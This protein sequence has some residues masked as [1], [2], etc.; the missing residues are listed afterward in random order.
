MLTTLVRALGVAAGHARRRPGLTV[1]AVIA[2][3]VASGALTYLVGSATESSNVLL[4]DFNQPSSR[5]MLIRA[6][7]TDQAGLLDSTS[8]KALVSLPGIQTAV[9]LTPVASA[10]NEAIVGADSNIGFFTLTT[11]SGADPYRLVS[12][13][14][15]GPGEAVISLAGASRINASIP[16]ASGIDVEGAR[17]GVVGTYT[18]DD[19][20]RISTLISASALTTTDTAP[21]GFALIALTVKAPADLATVIHALPVVFSTRAPTDYSTEYDPRLADVQKSISSASRRGVRT[22]AL[23]LTGAG[24]AITALVTAINALTQ[25]REIARRRALGATRVL[26]LAILTAET[27]IL[28]SFGATLGTLAATAALTARFHE[29]SPTLAIAAT[30]LVS[31]TAAIAALPGALFGAYQDP[32]KTLRVP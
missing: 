13:R 1:A 9:G 7:S 3:A 26:T 16:L 27:T 12:G 24:A 8:V 10:S 11:L 29:I 32:A 23:G 5:S 31:A 19:N 21:D 17:Y 15:P 28:A 25:R 2:S 14:Q 22:T 6:T 4:D 20:S 30:V 18:T